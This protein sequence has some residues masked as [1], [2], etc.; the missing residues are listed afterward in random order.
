MFF[1]ETQ[2]SMS[3]KIG[4]S[5]IEKLKEIQF[6]IF[7]RRDKGHITLFKMVLCIIPCNG[8]CIYKIALRSFNKP[9]KSTLSL[10]DFKEAEVS[11]G[12]KEVASSWSTIPN[13]SQ[14]C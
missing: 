1:L 7:C 10:L 3:K 11:R 2:E 8:F 9:L 6:V 4:D 12:L 14:T 5:Y 13:K